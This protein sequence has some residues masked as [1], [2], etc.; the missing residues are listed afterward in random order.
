MNDPRLG[1]EPGWTPVEP[2]RPLAPPAFV[3]GDRTG[4]RLR[5]RYY[6]RDAT[7]VAKAWFGPG[8]EGPP[9]HAHGGSIAAVLDEAMGAAGFLRR[10]PVIAS[11]ITI[12]FLLP[13]PLGPV[14][15]VEARVK[16]DMGRVLEVSSIL[17]GGDGAS[18]ASGEGVFAAVGPEQMRRFLGGAGEAG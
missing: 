18:L 8:A 14:V 2:F 3:S 10:G 9:G 5:V 11:Q 1:P 16:R 4:D 7:L 13:V 6:L 15:L 17:L 12:R